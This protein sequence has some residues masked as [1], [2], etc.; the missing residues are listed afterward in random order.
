MSKKRSFHHESLQEPDQIS[1]I[2]SALIE[3]FEKGSIKLDDGSGKIKLK[4]EGLL[5][6]DLLASKESGLNRLCIK[7]SWR[8]QCTK[9]N[10]ENT[11]PLK[12]S[13][14]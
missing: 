13:G 2:L 10:A 5:N 8:D 7:I 6:L 12:I 14:S 9:K 4:P 11:P 1:G 3:G